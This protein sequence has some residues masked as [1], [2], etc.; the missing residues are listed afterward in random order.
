MW[1]YVMILL[2]IIGLFGLLGWMIKYKQYYGLISGFANRSEEEKKQLIQNGYPQKAGDILL[3][4]AIVMLILLPI[5]FTSFLY[6]IEVQLGF[7]ITL[8]MSGFIYLSK[9]EIPSKRKRSYIISSIISFLSLGLFITIFVIG[10]QNTELIMKETTFAIKGPYGDEWNFDDVTEIQL[11]NEMPEVTWKI[12]GFGMSTA[13]KG[14]F[15]V[16][17]YGKSLLLIKKEGPYIYMKVNDQLIFIN[18]D[19]AEETQE[20]YEELKRR[21]NE[22]SSGT[23]LL[24]SN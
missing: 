6:F 22:G 24:L 13:S 1:L 10:Y 5:V 16:V 18:G 9:Y 19:T 3:L 11:M 2:L 12:N 7:M 23:V 21:V 17:G 4:T 15:K 20:W 14:Y 8:L